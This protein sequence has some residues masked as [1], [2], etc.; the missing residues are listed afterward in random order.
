MSDDLLV[1]RYRRVRPLGSGGMGDVWLAEDLDLGRRVAVKRLRV[2]VASHLDAELV[3][4]MLREARVVARLKHPAIVTMHDLLRI[5]GRPYLIMEYVEGESLAELTAREG[6]LPWADVAPVIADIAGALAEAHRAGIQHRDVKPANILLDVERRGHLADFGIARGAEDAAITRAGE[7]VGTVAYMPPEIARSQGSTAAS[8]VWSLGATFFAAVEGAAPFADS[9]ASVPALLVRLINED[10]PPP[11]RAGP[12]THLL[13]RML[14]TDP[15]ARPTAAEVAAEI[16]RLL[17]LTPQPTDAISVDPPAAETTQIASPAAFDP[18]VDPPKMAVDESSPRRSRLTVL[19]L[20]LLLLVG[21][22]VVGAVIVVGQEDEPTASEPT[23]PASSGPGD[24]PGFGPVA[25]GSDPMRMVLSLDGSAGYVSNNDSATLSKID[26]ATGEVE[27][28]SVCEGP[29]PATVSKDGDT[30]Y[31]PCG[32]YDAIAIVDTTQ[33]PAEVVEVPVEAG[34]GPVTLS[35]D[36]STLYVPTNNG[37]LSFLDTET[38]DP[39]FGS[40]DIGSSPGLVVLSPDGS[41]GYVPDQTSGVV[42]AFSLEDPTDNRGVDILGVPIEVTLNAAGTRAYVPDDYG[43]RIA[44]IDLTTDP[45]TLL[46]DLAFAGDTGRV[47]INGDQAWVGDFD[48]GALVV[49]DLESGSVAETIDLGKPGAPVVFDSSGSTAY[50]ADVDAGQVLAI[51]TSSYD[52]T[53]IDLD[54]STP[55]FVTISR[56]DSTLYVV[57]FADGDK[58]KGIVTAIPVP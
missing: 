45:E 9:A 30:V 5:E 28:I 3:E 29:V 42:V 4:R 36:E 8:D 13:T 1:D 11:R 41:T 58:K 24:S 37:R 7:L 10:A 56:D 35:P 49:I 31:V 27:E 6:S 23:G 17:A 18:A 53:R 2:G 40:L 34:P 52:V 15:T 55:Q 38:L 47:R 19:F 26:T 50:M 12:M 25:L 16:P 32:R 48:Q 20:V 22:A 14:A 51:D 46:P 21:A 43:G 39:V 33:V 57:G 54:G 44:V